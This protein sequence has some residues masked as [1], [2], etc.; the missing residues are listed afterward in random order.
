MV[1]MGSCLVTLR[2]ILMVL[3]QGNGVCPFPE[4]LPRSACPS[5]WGAPRN[6][7]PRALAPQREKK[8]DSDTDAP[9]Q[10]PSANPHP[11]LAVW[12]PPRGSSKHR[13]DSMPQDLLQRIR[14]RSTRACASSGVMARTM[15]GDDDPLPPIFPL[16]LCDDL[17]T[18]ES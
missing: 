12:R 9:A 5:L 8:D 7:P 16:L 6:A 17:Q 15:R 2:Q 11:R 18:R 1:R 4:V 3:A 10:R 14:T 13:G